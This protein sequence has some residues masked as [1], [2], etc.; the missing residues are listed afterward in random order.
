MLLNDRQ[1]CVMDGFK[2]LDHLHPHHVSRRGGRPNTMSTGPGGSFLIKVQ[3][4]RRLIATRLT[5]SI[6]STSSPGHT[7][8]T[9]P[10][11]GEEAKGPNDSINVCE[12]VISNLFIFT[13][14]FFYDLVKLFSRTEDFLHTGHKSYVYFMYVCLRKTNTYKKWLMFAFPSKLVRGLTLEDFL[15]SEWSVPLTGTYASFQGE[16]QVPAVLLQTHAHLVP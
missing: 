2:F 6:S 15:Y 5:P 4:S 3:A 10:P 7:L 9:G 16:S 11:E 14:G 1:Y 8:S 13:I 12:H